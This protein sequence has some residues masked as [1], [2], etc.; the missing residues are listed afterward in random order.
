M[1][2]RSFEGGVPFIWNG[3]I[4]GHTCMLTN[5]DAADCPVI[6]ESMFEKPTFSC[7]IQK[8]DGSCERPAIT[9]ELGPPGPT[10]DGSCVPGTL[11]EG[12]YCVPNPTGI[13]PDFLDLNNPNNPNNNS[14]PQTTTPSPDPPTPSPGASLSSTKEPVVMAPSSTTYSLC[15]PGYISYPISIISADA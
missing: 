13:P 4:F 2:Q 6:D 12:F 5:P 8:R 10:C 11:C 15:F 3:Q 7:I 9:Y 14:L 1:Y